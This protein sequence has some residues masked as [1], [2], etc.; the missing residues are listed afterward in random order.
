MALYNF[1]QIKDAPFLYKTVPP[2]NTH[3]SLGRVVDGS[4]ECV[5]CDAE[6]LAGDADS[7][8]VQGL[9][10]DLETH[11]GLAEQVLV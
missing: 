4:V 9:H 1:N 8:A 6:G 7:A 3:L 11:A 2:A 10:R 5:L